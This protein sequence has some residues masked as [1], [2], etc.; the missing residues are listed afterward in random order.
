MRSPYFQSI[1][2]AFVKPRNLNFMPAPRIITMILGNLCPP[3]K[4][5]RPS[6]GNVLS[7]A[8]R[9]RDSLEHS[10]SM[11]T[12]RQIMALELPVALL[13]LCVSHARQQKCSRLSLP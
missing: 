3:S 9:C 12:C 8:C 11:R 7:R 2:I 13:A 4:Q 10:C 1:I 5:M 6:K